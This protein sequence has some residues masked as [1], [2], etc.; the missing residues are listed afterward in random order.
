MRPP[1]ILH[2]KIALSPAR[3]GSCFISVLY[4]TVM[5]VFCCALGCP[6]YHRL[7]AVLLVVVAGSDGDVGVVTSVVCGDVHVA[8]SAAADV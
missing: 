5:T 7:L 6:A 2:L 3:C 4:N 8:S 1:D